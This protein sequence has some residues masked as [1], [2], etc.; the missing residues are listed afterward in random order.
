MK[1]RWV[2]DQSKLFAECA[3]LWGDVEQLVGGG[4]SSPEV[5]AACAEHD[6]DSGGTEGYF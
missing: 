2:E 1:E 5:T 6:G 4:V 3:E